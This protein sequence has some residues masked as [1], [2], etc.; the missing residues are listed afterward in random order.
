MDKLDSIVEKQIMFMD[1]LGVPRLLA[2]V[3]PAFDNSA[4]SLQIQ[5]MIPH[6][7]FALTCELGEIGDEI[8]WKS[9]KKKHKVV[10]M[11]NL[12]MELVDAF[13]FLLEIMIMCGMDAETIYKEYG[14][15]MVENICRQ[16]RNY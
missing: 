1:R 3:T 15:K 8:N 2:S 4:E 7:M 12:R 6:M 10:N 13:H 11:S 9:W 16:E 5:R 14:Y